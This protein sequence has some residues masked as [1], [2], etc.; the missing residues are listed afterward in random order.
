MSDDT[1]KYFIAGDAQSIL[2]RV[3]GVDYELFDRVTA[4]GGTMGSCSTL[5]CW[6]A[7]RP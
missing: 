5:S 2:A 4:R 3:A 6:A 7:P 1:A